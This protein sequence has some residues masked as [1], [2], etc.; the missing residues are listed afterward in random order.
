[1]THILLDNAFKYKKRSSITEPN[2]FYYNKQIGAWLSSIDQQPLVKQINFPS[3][4]TKKEDV[5][6]GEDQKGA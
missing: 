5:E 1:M 6:T 4:G 3:V 2:G